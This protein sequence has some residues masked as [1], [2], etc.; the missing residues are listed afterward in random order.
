[1]IWG[2]GGGG[3]E[4]AALTPHFVRCLVNLKELSVL[5][6]VVGIFAKHLLSDFY[7]D[8]DEVISEV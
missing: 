1:M 7:P 4:W 2:G 8:P 5:D 6:I 3:G